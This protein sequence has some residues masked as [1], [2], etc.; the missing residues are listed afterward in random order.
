MLAANAVEVVQLAVGALLG[1]A[2]SFNLERFGL[3]L[4]NPKTR[5][6]AV[7]VTVA[8]LVTFLFLTDLFFN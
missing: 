3:T 2:V 6:M 7:G 8:F 4:K 5:W 1:T